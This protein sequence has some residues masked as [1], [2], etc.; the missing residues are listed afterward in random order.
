MRLR[1]SL[2]LVVGLL[3]TVA[4]HA[5][6]LT[7]TLFGVVRDES[8]AV[9]PGA[10]VTATSPAMPGGPVTVVSNGQGEYRFVGLTP[11]V[12]KLSI[13]LNGFSTYEEA[14]L[15]V[16]AGGTTERNVGLVLATVAETIT[17]SG[18]SPVVDTRRAGI[19]QTQSREVVE[20]IPVE[21]RGATDYMS[22]LPG[23]TTSSYNSTNGASIMGS[24]ANEI[25]MTQDGAQYNNVVSGGGYQ[26]GDLDAVEEVTVTLLG[27]SA[28]YQQAQG[29]VMNLVNKS[30]TNLFR[31]DGRYY[32]LV[33][34]AVAVPF[35]L[36]CNC[37]EGNTGFKFQSN[38]D[39]SAHGGGPIIKDR[40]WFFG[41]YITVNW[42]YRQPGEATQP[43]S[44]DFQRFDSRMSGKVNYKLSDKVMFNQTALYE[45]WQYLTPFPS[46]IRPIA[47]TG[48]YPGD[49]R[50]FG[51]ELTAT[52]NSSTFL[53]DR[54]T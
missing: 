51:S 33:K 49:I 21:R 36:P 2:F 30:G 4:V 47:T 32:Y 46:R 34:D 9:L 35:T 3:W 45:W 11:G 25:T 8:R 27:A 7:G 1:T 48:W 10:T 17:V 54:Y 6:G 12:Y 16:A 13:V 53:T 29:G 41:G 44:K 22:R 28:E 43:T 18:Q 52:L 5:Q 42:Q 14:D 24:P 26:I 31:G 37:P 20:T 40:L 19:A 23:A 38:G 50:L 15:R 39:Y